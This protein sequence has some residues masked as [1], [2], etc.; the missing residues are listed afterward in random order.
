MNFVNFKKLLRIRCSLP[1]RNHPI[2]APSPAIPKDRA[3]RLGYWPP[4]FRKGW[5]WRSKLQ[6]CVVEYLIVVLVLLLATPARAQDVDEIIAMN[7]ETRGGMEALMA[8][9]SA[10]MIGTINMGGMEM[11]LDITFK[12]PHKIRWESAM[13]GMKVIRAYDGEMGWRVM[14]IMGDPNPVLMNNDELKQAEMQSDFEGPLVNYAAKDHS[15]EFLGKEASEGIEA[16]KLKVTLRNGAVIIMY[17]DSE[18][19]L[20]FK[21]EAKANIQGQEVNVTTN[22]GDYKAVGDVV[23]AHATEEIFEGAPQGIT[24]TISKVKINV[25]VD[26][27]IFAM[28]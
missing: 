16:Y 12:R 4:R 5:N 10:H 25:D 21:K 8:V 26:D 22:L 11:P 20:V 9:Q 2:I 28:P 24:M 1:L 6:W 18:Y 19:Y 14:P 23:M 13:Q 7:I 27:S 3:S 15:V 17:L